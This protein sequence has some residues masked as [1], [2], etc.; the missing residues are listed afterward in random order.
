MATVLVGMKSCHAEDEHL[1]VVTALASCKD[2]SLDNV[3]R[4][5]RMTL[6]EVERC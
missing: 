5:E 2:G 1:T 4:S 6:L 3:V